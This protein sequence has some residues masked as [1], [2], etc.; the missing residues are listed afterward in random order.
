MK[1]GRRSIRSTI[2]EKLS[3][4][5]GTFVFIEFDLIRGCIG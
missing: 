1:Y 3:L 4:G 5:A 2:V